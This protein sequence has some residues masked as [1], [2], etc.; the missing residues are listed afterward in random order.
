MIDRRRTPLILS[1]L[2]LAISTA[3]AGGGAWNRA[4]GGYYFKIGLNSLSADEEFG[5]GGRRQPIFADTSNFRDGGFGMTD[6]G[7]YGEVGVTDWLTAVASTQFKVAVREAENRTTRRDTTA[8]ASGLG[9]LWLDGRIRL[10]PDDVPYVAA[11]T[12]GVKLPTGSPY[13]QVPLGSGVVDYEAGLAVGTG[14]PVAG[15]DGYAQLFGGYRLRNNASDEINYLMEVGVRLSESIILQ[16]IIDGTHSTA[17]FDAAGIGPG[18]LSGLSTFDQ[19][20]ARW[21]LGTIIGMREGLD[22]N[23]GYGAHISGRNALA[24]ST[25]LIG[26]A[27]KQ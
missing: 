15:L 22:L 8:S 12:I 23:L 3:S 18:D 20:Y 19:S 4:P 17:D 11:L 1:L 25:I 2:L 10:A 9:D 21:T 14:F 24:G 16:G 7:F 27:W 13:Q 6:I 5:R 26:V